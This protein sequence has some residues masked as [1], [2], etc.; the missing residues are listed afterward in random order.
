MSAVPPAGAGTTGDRIVLRGLR[1]RGRHG[2]MPAERRDGQDFVI[3][4]TV[5]LDLA[6]AGATD[7]LSDTF[8]YGALGRRVAEIVAGPPRDLIETVAAAIADEILTDERVSVVEVAVHK[9]NAPIPLP[10]ADVAVV[11]RRDRSAGPPH[12]GPFAG[13]PHPDLAGHPHPDLAGHPHP[14][15]AGL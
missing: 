15:G 2:V 12:P 6:R 9:P 8:D 10:F 14:G 4:L 1:V 13:H 5:W 7:A 3:D 11:I